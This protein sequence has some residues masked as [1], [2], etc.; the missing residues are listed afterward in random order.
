MFPLA[1]LARHGMAGGHPRAMRFWIAGDPPVAVLG[2]TEDG[3][4]LPQVPTEHA[5]EAAKAVAGQRVLGL[6]GEGT[7][8]AALREAMGLGGVSAPLDTEEPLFSLDLAGLRMPSSEG[9]ALAPLAAAPRDLLLQWR[10]AYGREVLGWAEDAETQAERDID[11]DLA[12]GQHRV[13]LRHGEPVAMTGFNARLPGIVQ[14][15]G[16]WTPPDLRGQGLARAAVGLHLAEARHEGAKRAI[17]FSASEMAARAY[18]A[19]GFQ[20]I[21]RFTLLIFAEPQEPRHA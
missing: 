10:A 15:G 21:G 14:V 2:A 1:N 18:R 8:V 4:V 13:L 11:G 16:V 9:L 19:L 12:Q 20:E 3:M 17:L 5:G 6:L 7:Q